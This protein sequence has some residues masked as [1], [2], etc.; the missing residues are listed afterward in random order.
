MVRVCGRV[1]VRLERRDDAVLL[2]VADTGCGIPA[3]DQGHIFERFYR[4]DRAR[5]RELGGCGLG[6]AICK[7]IVDAHEGSIGFTSEPGEG[8]TFVVRLRGG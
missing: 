7:S 6:L 2:S 8:T 1:E 5:S 3:E 4:I